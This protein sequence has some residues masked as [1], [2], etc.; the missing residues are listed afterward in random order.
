MK[1]HMRWVFVGLFFICIQIPLHAQTTKQYEYAAVGGG[2]YKINLVNKNVNSSVKDADNDE[3]KVLNDLENS[4]DKKPSRRAL[5]LFL[6]KVNTD[7]RLKDMQSGSKLYLH[8]AS[9]FA[10]L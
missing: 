7:S 4:F 1:I 5:L 2:G 6:K 10:R 3:L 9:A 8:L